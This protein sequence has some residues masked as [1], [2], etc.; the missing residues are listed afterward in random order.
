MV[1]NTDPKSTKRESVREAILEAMGRLIARLGY[2]KTTVEDI[3][4]EVGIG[5]GTVYLHFGSKEEI[6]LEWLDRMHEELMKQLE[7]L[8]RSSE[9]ACERAKA[10]LVARVLLRFDRFA[11][12]PHSVEQMMATLK[13][14]LAA[15]KE[16]F[17]AREAVLLA[18][19]LHE[20]AC[21]NPEQTDKSAK[22]M[23]V[24]TNALLPYSLRTIEIGDRPTVEDE[25]SCIAD[26][27]VTGYI[28]QATNQT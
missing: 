6:A 9:S 2:H 23:I 24:A 11:S 3:A 13:P 17:H 12:Y 18:C 27:C 4:M 19:I 25:A 16:S 7:A 10:L 20:I 22:A 26:L 28:H 1:S 21:R 8:A 14:E 15:R 5:K